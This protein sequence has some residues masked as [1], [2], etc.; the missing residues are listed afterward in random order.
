MLLKQSF[1]RIQKSGKGGREIQLPKLLQET[2]GFPRGKKNRTL[3]FTVFP[4]KNFHGG[5][6]NDSSVADSCIKFGRKLRV[7]RKN[8]PKQNKTQT[9]CGSYI[10]EKISGA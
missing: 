10:F 4:R 7:Y 3:R 2:D 9:Y 6:K 1:S 5:M 8:I